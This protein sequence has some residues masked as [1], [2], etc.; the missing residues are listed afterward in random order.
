MKKTILV[1]LLCVLTGTINLFSQNNDSLAK[2][3]E[4]LNRLGDSLHKAQLARDSAFRE[5]MNEIMRSTNRTIEEA[6]QK[7]IEE[8]TKQVLKQ[9]EKEQSAKR[10]TML[11][12]LSA[13]LIAVVVGSI[14]LRRKKFTK[15]PQ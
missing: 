3:M 10:R 4:R 7:E 8:A 9:H 12:A 1:S 11:L 15:D 2:E 14:V 5:S 6:K 13:F